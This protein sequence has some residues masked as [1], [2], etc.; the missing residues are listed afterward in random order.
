MKGGTTKPRTASGNTDRK[1]ADTACTLKLGFPLLP[2]VLPS[3]FFSPSKYSDQ[4][5]SLTPTVCR[6]LFVLPSQLIS[7]Q[8][9]NPA[10][11]SVRMTY[12]LLPRICL[13]RP[14]SH[15][16]GKGST[17]WLWTAVAGALGFLPPA[18]A[19]LL[20]VPQGSLPQMPLPTT[21]LAAADVTSQSQNKSWVPLKFS[22]LFAGNSP[23]GDMRVSHVP[24]TAPPGYQN[25]SLLT[26]R[27]PSTGLPKGHFILPGLCRKDS[28]PSLCLLFI[29]TSFRNVPGLTCWRKLLAVY[30]GMA[31]PAEMSVPGF[32]PIISYQQQIYLSASSYALQ[33]KT[34]AYRVLGENWTFMYKINPSSF[35]HQHVNWKFIQSASLA[36]LYTLVF[37]NCSHL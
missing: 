34:F 9:K 12:R 16:R 23:S 10:A 6:K 37:I 22:W 17:H 2:G 11:F 26:R 20:S 19:R 28:F 33:S 15:T 24:A 7:L 21:S 35:S 8:S 3:Q 32:G 27:H 30:L 29:F 31:F 25:S 18:T 1:K 14:A 5:F 13:H 36:I 4:E